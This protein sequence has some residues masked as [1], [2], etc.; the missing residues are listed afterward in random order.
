MKRFAIAVSVAV[1]L[2][3]ASVAL[4]AGLS[5]TYKTTI[6]SAPLG[7]ALKGTWTIKFNSPDYTVTDNGTA[8]IR[9]KY[10]ITGTRITFNDKSGK[11]ACPNPGV[12]KFALNGSKL[13]FARVS[14]SAT[15]CAGR[16]AVLAGSYTKVS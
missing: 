3:L 9:G 16:E 8:V 7:G 11:D 14:D 6:G 15:K 4:A 12:Y 10:S 5:G 1:V 2:V 13:K